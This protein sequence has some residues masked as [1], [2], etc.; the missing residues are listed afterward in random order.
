MTMTSRIS[1]AAQQA[2]EWVK[3]LCDDARVEEPTAYSM[4]RAVLHQLRDRLSVEEAAHLGAQLPTMIRGLYYEGWTPKKMPE[5]SV[6]SIA[7]FYEGV[8]EKLYPTPVAPE[9]AVLAVFALLTR[10]LDAGE[11]KHVVQQLP[12]DI[13]GL[14]PQ[15]LRTIAAAE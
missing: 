10:N 9:H 6:R 13:A 8:K 7:D 12:N 2:Q 14:W 3:E 1:H 15:Q 4:L 5:T 11:L